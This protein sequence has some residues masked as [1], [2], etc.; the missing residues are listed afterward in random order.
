M[1]R[2]EEI[3]ISVRHGRA[4]ISR[5]ITESDGSFFWESATNALDL[6]LEALA[7]VQSQGGDLHANGEYRCPP[8]LAA[9]AHW[10]E[11]V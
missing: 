6:E 9:R 10:E 2:H 3:F 5:Y 8:E 11:A 1:T 7:A 4:Y